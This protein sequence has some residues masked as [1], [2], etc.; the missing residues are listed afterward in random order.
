MIKQRENPE[1]NP[2]CRHCKTMDESIFHILNSCCYLSVSM[3]LPVRHNE[4]AKV[5]YYGLLNKFEDTEVRKTPETI[6]RTTN[7]EVWWDKKITVQPPIECN[8]P[9]IVLWDLH[10]R[11]CLIIDIC[12]PM[13]VNVAREEKVKCDKYVLLASRLQRLYPQYTYEIVPIVVGSTGFISKKL[14]THLEQCGFEKEKVN[15]L[16]PILQRKA[17]RG[18]MKIVKTALKLRS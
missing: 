7:V 12:V 13:D 2:K 8:R 17:L 5:V 15:T 11:K 3:Y 14:R 9:D 10:K 4:V 18:S 1:S 16:I 6:T